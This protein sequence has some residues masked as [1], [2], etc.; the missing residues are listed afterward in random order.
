MA[1]GFAGFFLGL[2]AD[3]EKATGWV[4]HKLSLKTKHR[5]SYR[6]VMTAHSFK[7][8]FV[9]L[10][11][12]SGASAFAQVSVVFRA[13]EAYGKSV[14]AYQGERLLSGDNASTPLE[15]NV[16]IFSKSAAPAS[17]VKLDVLYF[18]RYQKVNDQ[19]QRSV[20]H[21]IEHSGL[22]S[23]WNARKAFL[24]SDKD[25]SVDAMFVYSK[26]DLNRKQLSVHLLISHKSSIYTLSALEATDYKETSFSANYS[27]LPAPLKEAA[28]KYWDQ[29][30]KK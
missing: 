5:A 12:L 26:H 24:D 7:K 22:L 2:E 16:F 9:L 29:L 1:I 23:V 21:A 11:T 17:A 30:D 28:L 19:W 4:W 27:E 13:P 15:D 18:Q 6:Q 20:F 8:W 10:L 14:F 3:D 25:Q